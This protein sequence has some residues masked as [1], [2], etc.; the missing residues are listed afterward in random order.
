VG[1][2]GRIARWTLRTDAVSWAQAIGG[3]DPQ[4]TFTTAPT[5]RRIGEKAVIRARLLVIPTAGSRQLVK[6]SLRFFQ[7]GGIEALREPVANWGEQIAGFSAPA[8]FLP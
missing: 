8:L 2:I 4:K 3:F 6:Q 1:N 7:V 5:D